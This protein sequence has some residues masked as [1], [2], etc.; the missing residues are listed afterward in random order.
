MNER[1]IA[2]GATERIARDVALGR[3][4]A[5]DL[6][7]DRRDAG[8]ADQLSP[9]LLDGSSLEVRHPA[10]H[11]GAKHVACL[12][13]EPELGRR[14]RNG[15]QCAEVAQH[16]A[17]LGNPSFGVGLH[18][19]SSHGQRAERDDHQRDDEQPHRPVPPGRG[20]CEGG[21]LDPPA[22][23]VGPVPLAAS[24]APH[25]HG[26]H[27]D[28]GSGEHCSS[29]DGQQHPEVAHHGDVRHSQREEPDGGGDGGDRDR[30]T[31]PEERAA[32]RAGDIVVRVARE[33]IF[34]A[35]VDLDREVDTQADEDRE[36]GD[37]H[38]RERDPEVA[39]RA[40]GPDHAERHH[41]E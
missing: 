36:P 11:L 13:H 35:T 8:G 14:A 1:R 33:L 20:Q 16:R 3:F 22:A 17:V 12:D 30:G 27:S 9:V 29:S 15:A 19:H 39:D 5:G 32:E 34:V 38:H 28:E 18:R 2:A 10:Q 21:P 26:R 31:Q 24:V 23:T 6:R 40:E 37:G 4:R 25:E 41:C 7:R